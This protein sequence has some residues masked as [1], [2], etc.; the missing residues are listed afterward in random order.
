MID[1]WTLRGGSCNDDDDD[2]AD[3]ELLLRLRSLSKAF[4]SFVFFVFDGRGGSRLRVFDARSVLTLDVTL[5]LPS[6]LVIKLEN[7]ES[8]RLPGFIGASSTE[9]L[10][11]L[12]GIAF[13]NFVGGSFGDFSSLFFS[14]LLKKSSRFLLL[15]FTVRED[16]L[17]AFC[18]ILSIFLGSF[19]P[20]RAH[21]AL[22]PSTLV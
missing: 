18:E 5:M 20:Q 8:E 11:S 14:S 22:R 2:I 16:S 4:D 15:D 3:G 7:G 12:L 6:K 10:S 9:S 17:F 1:D 21:E 19:V 13:F